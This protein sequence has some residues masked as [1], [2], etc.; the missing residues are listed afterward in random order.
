M[1]FA[2]ILFYSCL[3]LNILEREKNNTT[4]EIWDHLEEITPMI[5]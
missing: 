1:E 2:R 5:T 3:H 4:D